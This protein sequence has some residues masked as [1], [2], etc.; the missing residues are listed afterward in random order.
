MISGVISA[1]YENGIFRPLEHP[2]GLAEHQQVQLYFVADEMRTPVPA[3]LEEDL[4]FVRETM[5]IWRVADQE[6]RRW[7]AEEASLFDE[8]DGEAG[9]AA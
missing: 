2:G 4:H 1:I 3:S 9:R 7:L 6:F 8:G 5:G